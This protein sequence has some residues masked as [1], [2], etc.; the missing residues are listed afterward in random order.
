VSLG[1]VGDVLRYP[2]KSLVGE[3]L[4]R[5]LVEERG[6]AGDRLW[7]VRDPDGR[8]GSGKSSRRFRKM[9]GLLDLEARYDGD[10]PVIGFPDGRVLRGDDPTVHD[11]LSEHVGRPVTL[12]R[13]QDVSHFDEGPVH[14]VTTASLDGVG[15]AHGHPVDP[16]HLRPNLV[17]ETAGAGFV[18]ETW[19]GRRVRIGPDVVLSVRSGMPRCVMVTMSQVGLPADRDLL[20]TVTE[21]NDACL[22]VVADVV[23]VGRVAVGDDVVLVDA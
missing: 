15:G 12:A 16:R 5:V 6:V 11:A 17:V 8:L 3:H 19:I 22:G 4:E 23:A 1:R 7:S 2:V 10:V 21:V 14:L 13:E 20:G 9:P 18:E